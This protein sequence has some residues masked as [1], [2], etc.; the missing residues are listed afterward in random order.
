MERALGLDKRCDKVGEGIGYYVNYYA[1]A[2]L[3]RLAR[4]GPVR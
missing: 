1:H 2:A 3:F 4:S